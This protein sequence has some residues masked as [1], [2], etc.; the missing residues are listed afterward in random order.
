MAQIMKYYQWP[1]KGT[2]KNKYKSDQVAD[3]LNVDFSK[4]TY[5]WAN[6]LN[7][8]GSSTTIQDTAVATLM[9]HC[10]VAVNMDY[11]ASSSGAYNND[12]PAALK[13][14]FGYDPNAQLYI[15]NYYTEAEWIS[16]MKTEL[17]ARRPILYGGASTD[18]SGHQFICDGYNTD[19]LFHFNWGWSGICNGYFELTSLNVETPGIG[20][21]TGGFSVG[22]DMVIGIQKPSAT[23]TASY[24]ICLLKT[25]QAS[26]TTVMK[27]QT[28]N[29]TYG[30][31]NYGGNTFDGAIALGL[32]QNN[33][34]VSLIKQTD[35]VNLL[36]YYGDANYTE[37]GLTIP[38]S[39]ANGTYQLYSLYKAT[40]QNSWS[41][42][43]AKVGTPNSLDVTVTS[44]NVTFATPDVYPKLAL[45]ESIKTVGNLYQNKTGRFSATIKNDGGEF[46]SYISFILT[47]ASNSTVTQQIDFDPINI[48]AGTTKTIEITG[49][50]TLTPNS[51]ILTL[52]YDSNNDQD[53]P[54]MTLL[55][56]S[57]YNSVSTS[58]LSTPTLAP[59]LS[60]TQKISLASSTI[61][62]GYTAELTATINNTG[63]YYNNSLI[64]FIFTPTG[65]TSVDYIG[66]LNVILDSN[67]QQTITLSK[68]INLDAGSYNIALYFTN[69]SSG[70]EQFAPNAYNMI[71]FTITN[72]PTGIEEASTDK[73][74]I[75]PNPVTDILY[76]QSPSL[77][78]SVQVLDISGKLLLEQKPLTTGN[79]PVS[80]SNLSKGV[81]L[82]KIET[83]E[84]THTEKFFKK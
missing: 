11:T 15:R 82:I 8:Y 51:Y 24:E 48:P 79:I 72:P 66:P 62:T 56:T 55:T 70:W 25:L 61:T 39:P 65:T 78:Q 69:A 2:G 9:Y 18:G 43:K 67:E 13:N 28:F 40:D 53:N 27:G 4:T 33:A 81:Y 23:S 45:T 1:V 19:N 49:D 58:I 54:S 38:A 42:M 46:N 57:N 84:G 20:G 30:F 47:S 5:N 22:Q 36:T 74:L 31:A 75:Y 21:G 26:A 76:I 7:T 73:L 10:G 6:M 32:Y 59:A 17:N 60:L 35:G 37:R 41:I 14:F 52:K 83:E 80:V 29:I 3:S 50:I 44:A 68:N 64:A 71:P 12:I 63:G 77:V 16:M 34:L